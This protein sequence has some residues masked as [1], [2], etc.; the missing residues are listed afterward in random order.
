MQSTFSR[1]R[2]SSRIWAPDISFGSA[3]L[4]VRWAVL[5]DIQSSNEKRLPNK[6]GHLV[7]SFPADGL[8]ETLIRIRS[9]GAGYGDLNNNNRKQLR[10][11]TNRKD[12]GDSRA[13]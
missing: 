3:T 12:S 6:K 11:L 10:K 2:H 5:V 9:G 8:F 13:G 7:G 4:V 1:T